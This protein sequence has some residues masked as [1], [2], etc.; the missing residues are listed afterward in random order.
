MVRQFLFFSFAIFFLT[1][2]NS[3]A[4]KN[5]TPSAQTQRQFRNVNWDMTKDEVKKD[6][7]ASLKN[8]N[9]EKQTLSYFG[10]TLFSK[11]A[12][13][14][15]QFDNTKLKK[16]SYFVELDLNE[17]P[18]KFYLLFKDSINNKFGK[19]FSDEIKWRGVYNEMP[20]G[21]R[22]L[23]EALLSDNASLVTW[24]SDTVSLPK[25]IIFLR[26][27]MIYGHYVF[28]TTNSELQYFEAKKN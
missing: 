22:N 25:R 21:K 7:T 5:E 14:E 9:P 2:C 4:S 12:E 1:N 23:N 11:P 6:E 10:I 27:D 13:L 16:A 24:W 18:I 20:L 28:N 19:P 8:E 17:D 3:S 15:Y 26:C